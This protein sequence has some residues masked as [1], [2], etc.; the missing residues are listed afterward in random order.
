M[1][2]EIGSEEG[3]DEALR[4]DSGQWR[5]RAQRI[6]ELEA[7]I[8]RLKKMATTDSSHHSNKMFDSRLNS[9]DESSNFSMQP[10][11]NGDGSSRQENLSR[12]GKDIALFSTSGINVIKLR[13]SVI[14]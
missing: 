10:R 6:T 7:E 8:V 12:T 9:P 2:R 1:L 14:P 5:G 11:D 13:I 4:G 3:V